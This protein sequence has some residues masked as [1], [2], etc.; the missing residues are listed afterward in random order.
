MP[1]VQIERAGHVVEHL[2]PAIGEHC[3]LVAILANRAAIMRDQD[4]IGAAH[5][6]A[7][8]CRAFATEPL[9]ADLGDLVNQVHI[10]VDPET[11]TKGK[12]GPHPSGI[13]IDRHLPVLG[14]MAQ[15]PVTWYSARMSANAVTEL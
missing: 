4:D 10:E 1:P 8:C 5:P 15:V 9:V 2:Q 3:G 11:R 13:S 6:F 12:P 14:I 7:K